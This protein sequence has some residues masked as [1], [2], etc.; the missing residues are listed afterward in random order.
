LGCTIYT[1]QSGKKFGFFQADKDLFA[2]VANGL[3]LT[4]R[5]TGSYW[6]ARH[7][8]SF[9]VEAADDICFLIIDFEDGYRLKRIDFEDIRQPF[10]AIINDDQVVDQAKKIR[11]EDQRIAYLRSKVINSLIGQVSRCF[12][13]HAGEIIDA[14]FD[15]DLI[16]QIPASETLNHVRMVSIREVY[17]ARD[18]VE[19]EAAGFEV[20]SGL[21]GS[22]VV[23]V[24]DIA[25]KG[26]KA[27]EK[28][29]KLVQLIPPQFLKQPHLPDQDGYIRILQVVDFVSGMTDSYAVTLFKKIRGISLPTG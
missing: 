29:K 16:S 24:N 25:T 2:Q 4:R 20:L 6:W 26:K 5:N 15:K 21:L 17:S 10:E 11:E 3:G 28:N 14:S 18:I 9:L 23:A 22:F 19:I 8:L 13:E 12:M 1:G 7:P 27:T